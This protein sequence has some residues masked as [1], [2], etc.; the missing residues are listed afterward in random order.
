MTDQDELD[1]LISEKL[2]AALAP[3]L[4][5]IEKLTPK[6]EEKE[7]KEGESNEKTDSDKKLDRAAE[8]LRS[9][10]KGFLKKEKLDA[11]SF[12]ELDIANQ[13]KDELPQSGIKN[14]VE[15]KNTKT[16]SDPKAWGVEV[17]T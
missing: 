16:D 1:K 4:E 17:Q 3:L 2:D 7:E 8:I 10:L 13:L 5:K 6:E 12:D 11:M 15:Q 9:N 14:P